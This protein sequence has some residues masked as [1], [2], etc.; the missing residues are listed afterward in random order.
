M[1]VWLTIP[2][3]RPPVEVERTLSL[4][5]NQGYRI[6]IWR[7]SGDAPVECDLLLQREAYPGYAR[8]V[9]AL[10]A[11]VLETD[12]DCDWCVAGGDDTEPDPNHAADEIA[13][14]CSAYF[15]AL[16]AC[17]MDNPAHARIAECRVEDWMRWSTFGVMQ[18][19]G[20]RFASGSIDRIA[21]SPWLGREWCLRANQGQGPFWP[22]FVHMFGDECLM[23]TAERLGVYWR[24]PDLI[25]FHHHFM[26]ASEAID[27]PAVQKPIPAHLVDWNSPR[28]WNA[29]KAIFKGLEAQDFEP[30][31]PL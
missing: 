7:D 19:T 22:E 23:R 3:K 6:A 8:A 14:E 27:S 1:S 2:S 17:R 15:G 9:N 24:R 5:R 26:R 18:P 31:M 30:C 13:A 25:H 10:C 29:M 11:A 21:G 4:W 16:H 20:D 28:H 12:P